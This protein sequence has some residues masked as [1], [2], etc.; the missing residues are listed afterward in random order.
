[1]SAQY[2]LYLQ[3]ATADGPA[4]ERL[5]SLRALVIHLQLA[6]LLEP[7]SAGEIATEL[8]GIYK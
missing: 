7:G 2:F 5:S 6:T 1:M 3:L 4:V 8:E